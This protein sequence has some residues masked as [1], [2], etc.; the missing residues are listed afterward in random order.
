MQTAAGRLTTRVGSS[1]KSGVDAVAGRL[2]VL[3]LK[4][5]RRTDPDR[6]A[7]AAAGF[8]RRVG[9]WLPEHRTGRANLAAAYPNKSAAEIEEI[10]GGV[11]DNLG[12]VAAEYAHFDRLWDLNLEDQSRGRI[13]FSGESLQRFFALRDDGK[14]ALVF[15]AHLANW[16]LPML[17][18]ARYGLEG[19]AL[20]RAP[21]IARI[22]AAVNE[23][24]STTVGTIATGIGAPAAIMAALERGIHVGIL[25]DQF[26]YQGI[27]VEFFGR[28]CKTNPIIARLARHFECPIH[29]TR[30]IRLP[31]NRFRLEMTP[32]I[33]PVRDSTGA[34]DIHATTQMI[35][36]IIEGWVREHPEQWLW[37]HR[38]WR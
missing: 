32:A 12:R 17:A 31:G 21:S 11:W 38:R 18:A 26:F 23:I 25:V 7:N 4:G 34:V 27:D 30:V 5:I 3:L 20:F 13:E 22:A 6:I 2:A 35:T 9:P 1:L 10:L 14:P 33:E 16:E 36:G 15:S 28:P 37:V 29:G 24:R 8:M 19:A